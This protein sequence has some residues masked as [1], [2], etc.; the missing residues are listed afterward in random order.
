MCFS[1]AGSL[2]LSVS[3][4]GIGTVSVAKSNLGP[5]RLFAA[6]PFLFAAQQAAEA[7]VWLTMGGGEHTATHR[8]AVKAFLAV[9]LVIWPLWVP[10]ALRAME[11][12]PHRHRTLT[13]LSG[14]G[15]IVGASALGLLLRWQPTARV[16]GHSI[17]Y[18]YAGSDNALLHYLLVAAYVATTIAPFFVSTIHLSK[19]VGLTLVASLVAA[20]LIQRE[21][22]TSVWC[23]FAAI[24]SGVVLL[25]VTRESQSIRVDHAT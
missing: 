2:A 7:V 25:A 9:A 12:D 1:A 19:T 5:R 22:L 15:A 20:A 14:F 13:M 16:V 6:I 8:L 11:R 4:A 3:L 21:A 10:A 17:S 18:E 23:F 24:I